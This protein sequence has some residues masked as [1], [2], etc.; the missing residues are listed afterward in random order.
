GQTSTVG[1]PSVDPMKKPSVPGKPA[2][3]VAGIAAPAGVDVTS[4]P[5]GTDIANDPVRA[6]QEA[7]QY[8]HAIIRGVYPFRFGRINSGYL[9]QMLKRP[10]KNIPSA[11]VQ[12]GVQSLQRTEQDLQNRI[13]QLLKTPQLPLLKSPLAAADG[14]ALLPRDDQELLSFVQQKTA[15]A[16]SQ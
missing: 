2:A 16:T 1:S 6:Y 5:E 9:A 3:P 13:A 11:G 8:H 4:A 7:L 14:V 10:S 15:G 12:Q